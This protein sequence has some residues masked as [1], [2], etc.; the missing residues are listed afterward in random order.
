M[1]GA[2]RRF[3][4]R[5][6]EDTMKAHQDP[7]TDTG[8]AGWEGE[9]SSALGAIDLGGA[10]APCFP[11]LPPGYSAQEA[12]GFRDPTGTFSYEFRR[13]YGLPDTDDRHGAACHL[14]EGRSY[15]VVLW[16]AH[17]R[18]TDEHPVGRWLTYAQARKQSPT[19]LT[20]RHFS[21]PVDMRD[22]IPRLLDVAGIVLEPAL[23]RTPGWLAAA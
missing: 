12:W 16:R 23:V 14:D 21:S 3:A 17:G 10:L 5:D 18:S 15:W 8:L 9:G 2:G 11:A 19:R 1:D 20:F 13:V 6:A 4:R 22:E 7:V